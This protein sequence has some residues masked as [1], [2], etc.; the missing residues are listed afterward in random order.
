MSVSI[1]LS[2]SIASLAFVHAWSPQL[3][4][5]RAL[6]MRE[7]ISDLNESQSDVLFVKLPMRDP[8]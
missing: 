7:S 4:F 2:S 8:K 1:A 3:H 5:E 6:E